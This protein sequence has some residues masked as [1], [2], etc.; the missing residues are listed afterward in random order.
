MPATS[1]LLGSAFALDGRVHGDRGLAALVALHA[2]GLRPEILDFD[3]RREG[4]AAEGGGR[5]VVAGHAVDHGPDR[6]SLVHDAGRTAVGAQEILVSGR[7]VALAQVTG[8]SGG[9]VSSQ[10]RNASA[11]GSAW[12]EEAQSSSGEIS[13]MWL[14][15]ADAAG[16]K[17]VHPHQR[18]GNTRQHR[19]LRQW[20][21]LPVR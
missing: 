20:M 7:A 19:T 10:C 21:H 13:A 6:R 5:R 1:G 18:C 3:A 14:S 11:F 8:T 9:L 2:P 4:Y 12:P 16:G 15:S 17:Q